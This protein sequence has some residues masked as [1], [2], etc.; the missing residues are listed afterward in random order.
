[1][2]SAFY[3][4][5]TYFSVLDRMT[6]QHISPEAKNNFGKGRG[7]NLTQFPSLWPCH[8]T[9]LCQKNFQIKLTFSLVEPEK[10]PTEV[11]QRIFIH[12]GGEKILCKNIS[13]FLGRCITSHLS[14]FLLALLGTL[15][16]S[17]FHHKLHPAAL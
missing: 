4:V 13:S 3:Y 2:N 5:E 8:A 16:L 14:L 7:R 11:L 9:S 15:T 10:C 1:M 12:F 17:E 6:E